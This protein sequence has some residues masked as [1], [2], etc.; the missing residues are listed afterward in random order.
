MDNTVYLIDNA[1]PVFTVIS[2]PEQLPSTQHHHISDSQISEDGSR[3]AVTYSYKSDDSTTTGV[4]LALILIPVFLI[5]VKYL[6]Y[7][8]AFF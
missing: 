3:V 1:D 5:L 8:L 7:L 6:M 2:V 4:G